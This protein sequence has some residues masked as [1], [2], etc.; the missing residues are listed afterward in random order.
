MGITINFSRK[1]C[2]SFTMYDYLEDVMN[3][4]AVDMNGTAVTPASKNLFE[5]DTNADALDYKTVEYFHRMTDRLLF[6][7]KRE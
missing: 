1:D 4:A 6:V 3:E 2:V 7:S 5:V